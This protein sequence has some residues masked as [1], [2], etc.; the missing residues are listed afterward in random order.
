MKLDTIST[1]TIILSIAAIL[2]SIV[3]LLFSIGVLKVKRG[4]DACGK[5]RD[6]VKNKSGLKNEHEKLITINGHNDSQMATS[7]QSSSKIEVDNDHLV[8]KTKFENGKEI[9]GKNFD[10]NKGKR[11]ENEQKKLPEQK[12]EE[13]FYV[14][15]QMAGGRITMIDCGETS[16]AYM[17]FKIQVKNDIVK[18]LF[19]EAAFDYVA[20]NIETAISQYALCQFKSRGKPIKIVTLQS[21]KAFKEQ[22]NWVLTDKPKL[23]IS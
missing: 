17:P 2:L 9:G 13:I 12:K 3:S 5:K 22:N 14:Q 23:E 6:K 1:Y 21:G 20:G 19:N 16:K 15:P 10:K 11:R 4:K 7:L 18:V 8:E